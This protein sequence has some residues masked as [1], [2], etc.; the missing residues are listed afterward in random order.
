MM[1]QTQNNLASGRRISSA[2]DN[3]TNF[4]TATALSGR[5][6]QLSS[7]VDGISNS[8]Q[9]LQA[10]TTGIA[11]IQKLIGLGKSLVD[12]AARAD[13][14][15]AAPASIASVG[16]NYSTA[17]I[18]GAQSAS[19]PRLTD[20][21]A[22]NFAALHGD[23]SAT[24]FDF[25]SSAKINGTTLIISQSGLPS[26][27]YTFQRPGPNAPGSLKFADDNEL[28][29]LVAIDFPNAMVSTIPRFEI[30]ST[31]SDAPISVSGS[32]LG[33]AVPTTSVYSPADT[34]SYTTSAGL[35]TNLKYRSPPNPATDAA[36]GFFSSP[37]SFAQAINAVSGASALSASVDPSGTYVRLTA[38]DKDDTFTLAGSNLSAL[39]YNPA[40]VP[41]SYQPS[42]SLD[43]T[44]VTYTIGKGV[45]QKSVTVRYGYDATE[46]TTLRQLNDQLAQADMVAV[47]D[48]GPNGKVVVKPIAGREADTIT[49]STPATW[50]AT[51]PQTS[52]GVA[53]L[54]GSL[55]GAYTADATLQE[56]G[57]STR[58]Q[59]AKDY[60]ALL[61]QISSLARD[62]SYNGQNL[63]MGQSMK[64][65]LN[66]ND[67][68]GYDVP[69][70]RVD[71]AGLGLLTAR[72]GD[73]LDAQSL[74]SAS[75]QV[76]EASIQL[77]TVAQELATSYSVAKIRD[78]FT[79]EMTNVLQTGADNLTLADMSGEAAK[80]MALDVRR[81]LGTSALSS[82]N[83]AQQSILQLLR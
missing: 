31:I 34:F 12:R 70:A 43:D 71:A 2:L 79:R 25:S 57:A 42:P 35:T 38:A 48:P 69:G 16:S 3:P 27:T 66:E 24:S 39:G 30:R 55:S 64:V 1:A 5:S 58:R 18:V 44:E 65:R 47:L 40:P 23:L 54:T 29:Q 62:S 60:T 73:F 17:D 51:P 41:P 19:A 37:A 67:T 14:A 6:T 45:E 83:Q 49:L 32:A 80:A 13:N 10:A 46:T 81:Q 33:A 20:T 22:P 75:R 7:L 9:T 26:K 21:G 78:S 50:S 8:V 68:T 63:L 28:K 4:F 56:P 59:L 76:S 15:V 61:D 53:I 74:A 72:D 11:S 77:Q 52:T 82:S 36:N